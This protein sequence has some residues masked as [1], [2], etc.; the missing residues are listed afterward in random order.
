M[1]HAACA[2]WR[3]LVDD[4]GCL[5]VAAHAPRL[6]AEEDGG[7][8]AERCGRRCLHD[9]NRRTSRRISRGGLRRL[10]GQDTDPFDH[11]AESRHIGTGNADGPH[12]VVIDPQAG[13]LVGI[14]DE[15]PPAV[16]AMVVVG[17]ARAE[18]HFLVP[19]HIRRQSAVS[20]H[21]SNRSSRSCISPAAPGIAT[22]TAATISH[23]QH[24]AHGW[25][26]S[27]LAISGSIIRSP[28]ERC[29]IR[30]APVLLYPWVKCR[31]TTN[32]PGRSLCCKKRMNTMQAEY[33]TDIARLAEDIARRETEAAKRDKDNLRW[34]LT[35]WL[36]AVIVLGFLIRWPF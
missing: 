33:R 26:P 16:E 15:P 30:A 6:S 22:N 4:A 20:D 21:N 9:L 32:S 31:T 27:Y 5:V 36:A 35:L 19:D 10:R 23:D 18:E 1:R 34:Q 12:G 11:L 17:V 14:R 28:Q 13:E 24:H 3:N 8:A 25:P 7:P 29:R 2:V